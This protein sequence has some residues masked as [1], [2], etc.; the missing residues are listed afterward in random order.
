A[1]SVSSVSADTFRAT[2][3]GAARSLRSGAGPRAESA[4]W[5]ITTRTRSPWPPR[6]RSTRW[7]GVSRAAST[8][9]SSRR[10]RRRTSRNPMRRSWPRSSIFRSP[11]SPP[12]SQ[13]RSAPGP[14][15]FAL[16]WMPWRP[17]RRARRWWLRVTCGRVGRGGELASLRGGGAGAAVVGREGV[18]AAFAGAFGVS[19]EFT[20]VWRND[21]DRYVTALPDATFVKSHGLDLHVPEA[22]TGL[23]EKTG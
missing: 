1:R 3:S 5:R 13:D 12:T 21:G 22:I 4:P 16:R 23:L 14:P 19:H 9:A 17:D 10:R 15:R 11:S 7:P 8:P 20:D 18:I 2:G 6:P